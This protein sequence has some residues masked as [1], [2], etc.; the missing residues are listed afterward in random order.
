MSEPEFT[1]TRNEDAGEYVVTAL[2]F[3]GMESVSLN[4]ERADEL[5]DG[6]L[7][8]DD[9]TAEAVVRFLLERQDAGLFPRAIDIIEVLSAWEGSLERIIELKKA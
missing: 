3:A 5:S 7:G 2:G 9:Q 6:A 8:D 4:L 1:I